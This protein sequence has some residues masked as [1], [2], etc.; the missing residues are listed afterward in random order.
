MRRRCC[1]EWLGHN[2][3]RITNFAHQKVV[4][5]RKLTNK[6]GID[7]ITL[8][9]TESKDLPIFELLL[10]DGTGKL[11]SPFQISVMARTK[12]DGCRDTIKTFT[13]YDG[14]QQVVEVDFPEESEKKR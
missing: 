1:I 7:L 11:G 8:K 9:P 12:Q 3:I 10:D 2:E 13:I 5:V 14:R 4:D 6:N